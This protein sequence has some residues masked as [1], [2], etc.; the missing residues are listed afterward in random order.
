[1]EDPVEEAALG[2]QGEEEL[3]ILC[4]LHTRLQ[5]TEW[6]LPGRLAPRIRGESKPEVRCIFLAQG[7]RSWA[8]EGCPSVCQR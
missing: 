6:S 8:L 4:A 5:G 1:M 3:P 7:H 2:R